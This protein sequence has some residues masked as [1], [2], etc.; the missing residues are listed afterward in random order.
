LAAAAKFV[1]CGGPTKSECL[2][3]FAEDV[4]ACFSN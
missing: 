3:Q 2:Q 1:R 4:V